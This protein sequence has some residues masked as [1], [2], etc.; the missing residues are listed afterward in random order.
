VR[1]SVAG[2]ST[3]TFKD[4]SGEQYD[5][6]VRTPLTAGPPQAIDSGAKVLIEW[7]AEQSRVFSS[8]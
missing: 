8:Q 2:P 4:P 6:I 3:G 1:L 5:I 7:D